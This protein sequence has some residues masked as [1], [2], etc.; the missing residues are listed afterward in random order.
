M[1]TTTAANQSTLNQ[2][3]REFAE[4]MP[5][6]IYRPTAPEAIAAVQ[7]YFPDLV[8]QATYLPEFLDPVGIAVIVQIG[9]DLRISWSVADND[10]A[11]NR[12]REIYNQETYC[13]IRAALKIDYQWIIKIR[14]D[15][16]G[17]D[18]DDLIQSAGRFL[19]SSEKPDCWI[20][21][22]SD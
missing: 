6:V 2:E 9:P 22:L 8:E 11:A 12:Q 3:L 5:V 18:D 13:K 21:D 7:P 14:P 10:E 17:Y 19:L 1:L 16:W 4:G 15:F 20:L